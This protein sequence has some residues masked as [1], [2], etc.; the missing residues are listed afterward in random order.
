MKKIIISEA[1]QPLVEQESDLMSKPDFRC[2]IAK[3]WEDAC[4]I[5]QSENA[6]LL[7]ADFDMEG[8]HGDGF[9]SVIGQGDMQKKVAIF[10]LGHSADL[11]FQYKPDANTDS[12][13]MKPL[14]PSQFTEKINQLLYC[15]ERRDMR[16]ST[17]VTVK[18]VFM[19]EYF[20][21]KTLN[22][23]LSGILI[24]T[25]KV[26][27]LGDVITCSFSIPGYGTVYAESQ[28]LRVAEGNRGFRRYGMQ[29]LK[30]DAEAREAINSYVLS[31]Q[32]SQV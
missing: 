25:S 6:H 24:E 27:N 17:K 13:R 22:I 21:C 20:I 4:Q 29:F 9:Y 11:T 18:G 32:Q 8:V 19:N 26:L 31:T 15:S 10:I 14:E 1:L 16:A 7:I 3:S 28:V 5:H 12:S 23:S 30:L 2:F